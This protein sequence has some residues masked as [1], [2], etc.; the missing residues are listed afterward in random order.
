MAWL[1]MFSFLIAC[2]NA[3]PKEISATES[4]VEKKTSHAIPAA[5]RTYIYFPLLKGK[6]IA[7]VGNHTSLIRDIHLVDSLQNAGF[8]V[9]K[10]FSPEH[11]FRGTAP[12]GA[13]VASGFDERSGVMVISLYG[14]RRRPTQD[15]LAGI[16][17]ILVDM[18]DVGA[19]FYTYI[20]TMT[21]VMQEAARAGTP[22]LVLDRPNP[23]GHF[24]DGPMLDLAFSSFV[25]MHPVPV[26]HGM[27]IGE[28]A[29]MIN[30]EGWLGG[31]LEANL[32]VIPVANYSRTDFY[33]LPVPP[34][35]NLPNMRAI[36]LYPSLCF[37]EGTAISV[38]RGT[39][40]PFQVF[41]SPGLPQDKFSFTFTPQSVPASINPPL[42]SQTCFG[43]DLR[44]IPLRYL[45]A[46]RQLDLSYLLDAYRNFPYKDRFFNNFFD[47]LAGSNILRN[48]IKAGLNENQIR[49]S[50]QPGLEA[51]KKIRA[52][53]LIYPDF[54]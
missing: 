11:G 2:S 17:V 54:E 47:R 26:V 37:F 35:P 41:G 28:F 10:V 52:K 46:K 18:Q 14:T 16:D 23:I 7:L 42:L 22:V 27:T 32:K 19:R 21:L 1:L 38:G 8:Q 13:K 53:Y 31:E 24:V 9:D 29:L 4:E 6:R 5:E 51:F 36:Y 30:G 15:E 40:F 43:R 44:T 12:D 33:Q 3:R 20:S 50:W 48:Q 45:Q 25:G 39:E 34:S 49:Q